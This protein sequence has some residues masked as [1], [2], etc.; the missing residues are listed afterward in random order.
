MTEEEPWPYNL[1]IFR[2]A[3]VAASPDGKLQAEISQAYEVSMSSPTIGVLKVSNGLTIKRCN[4]SFIWSDDS[5][6]LAVPQLSYIL[7]IL[8]AVRV[9][10]VDTHERFVF[11]SR[12]FT[13]WIQPE[14]FASG[15]L[16][17][18]VD[19]SG[20]AHEVRWQIPADLVTFKRLPDEKQ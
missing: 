9:L 18:S 7:G 10:V 17:V 20:P 2:R 5:R 15:W 3:F 12:R 4:P 11:A 6:Y 1:P 8:L 14:S 19:P 13:A 16:I